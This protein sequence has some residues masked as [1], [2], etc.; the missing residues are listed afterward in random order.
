MDEVYIVTTY[1]VVD[2]I[3]QAF[4]GETKYNPKMT[5]AEIVLVAILAAKYFQNH[6]ERTLIVLR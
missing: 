2:D 4:L 6:L 1:T 3:C 5:P